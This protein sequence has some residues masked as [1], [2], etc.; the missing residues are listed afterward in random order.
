MAKPCT[1]LLRAASSCK[2]CACSCS[3][4]CLS[5]A[6]C[7]ASWAFWASSSLSRCCRIS[8]WRRSS[9]STSRSACALTSA[10]PTAASIT[11]IV[12]PATANAMPTVFMT[13][14]STTM[15][16]SGT[17]VAAAMA[18]KCSEQMAS[19]SSPGATHRALRGSRRRL[20][21]MAADGERHAEDHR[22]D[23]M[24][25]VPIQRAGDN[26][27]RHARVV[28]HA[29]AGADDGATHSH[30]R[31]R[32]VGRKQVAECTAHASATVRA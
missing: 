1:M 5:S 4:C 8:L 12:T 17:T 19:V 20:T 26:H 27:R 6:C 2:F 15:V 11:S 28:H 14:G 7:C 24:R 32:A 10:A 29:D 13:E 9:F 31:V 18:V 16:G 21:T 30:P 22:G 23:H 25:L 3:S